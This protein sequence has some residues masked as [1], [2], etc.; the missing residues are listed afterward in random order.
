MNER[1]QIVIRD[2]GELKLSH[3]QICKYQTQ[4]IHQLFTINKYL[5]RLPGN[6]VDS[7]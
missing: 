5:S 4:H 3:P 2:H 1:S 6:G 7:T